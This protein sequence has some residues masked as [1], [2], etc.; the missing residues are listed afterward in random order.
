M[1]CISWRVKEWSSEEEKRYPLVLGAMGSGREC[2]F[3][4][5]EGLLA[6]RMSRMP[7]THDVMVDGAGDGVCPPDGGI[8][9]A[10][11]AIGSARR[12]SLTSNTA[13]VSARI[14]IPGL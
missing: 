8:A 10:I 2:V 11:L 7:R 12:S 13:V 9:V 5:R 14:S 6:G 4:S 1:W 3:G